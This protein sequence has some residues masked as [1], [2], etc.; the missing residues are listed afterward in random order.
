MLGTV[1]LFKMKR[2]Q[3]AWVTIA[4]TI[5]LLICTLTAGWMKTFSADPKVGFLSHARKISD[6]IAQGTVLAPARTI[7]EM[8][9][10]ALNDYIDAA[11]CITFLLVVVS[12]A[13]Y[14]VRT[15]IAARATGQPTARETPYEPVTVPV[16]A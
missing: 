14:G 13:F 16:A 6:A 8:Q 2:G 15:I 3:Y 12:I 4:P 1:V 9:R 10:I 11:L 5:W 7:E